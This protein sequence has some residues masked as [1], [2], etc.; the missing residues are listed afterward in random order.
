MNNIR[1]IKPD[2]FIEYDTWFIF[3]KNKPFTK[4]K[5]LMNDSNSGPIPGY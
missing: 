5:L 1:Y 2:D 4:D 3:D